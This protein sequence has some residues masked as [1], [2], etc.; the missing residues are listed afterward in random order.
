MGVFLSRNGSLQYLIKGVRP[1]FYS[2][3]SKPI[4]SRKRKM[5]ASVVCEWLKSQWACDLPSK[6]YKFAIIIRA[7]S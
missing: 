5:D 2:C 7:V 3:A 4:Q 1:I 6:F